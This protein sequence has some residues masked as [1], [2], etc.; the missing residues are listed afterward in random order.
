MNR[1]LNPKHAHVFYRYDNGSDDDAA[2]AALWFALTLAETL[3][4]RADL[5]SDGNQCAQCDAGVCGWCGCGA[6][7]VQVIG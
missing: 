3:I 5:L 6:C 7:G 2:S 4:L 1:E